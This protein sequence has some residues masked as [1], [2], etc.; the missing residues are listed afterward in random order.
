MTDQI[1]RIRNALAERYEIEREI[2]RGGMAT[3]FRARDLRHKRAVAIKVLHAD[4]AASVGAD[5]FLREIETVAGLSHPHI[6]PLFDSGEAGGFLYYVMPYVDGESLRA[7]LERGGELPVAETVRVLGEVADALQY[8]HHRGVVHRD[9]KPENV[10]FSGRHALVTDFGV[11]KAVSASVSAQSFTTAGMAIG[12]P[13][14]MAPEQAAA[15]PQVDHRADLYALGVLGY[16]ML[17]GEPPFRGRSSQA[18]LAA[19]MTQEPEP[20]DQ[21]RSGAPVALT[22]V[23][24]Q[25]LAK[26]PADRPQSAEQVQRQLENMPVASGTTRTASHPSQKSEKRKAMLAGAAIAVVALVGTALAVRGRGVESTLDPKR[27]VVASFENRTGDSSLDPIG[28]MAVDWLT[29]GLSRT[30][31][32]QVVD[33]RT[34]L[35]EPG[36][37]HA[38][39][40]AGA[41]RL[42]SLAERT[43][44]GTVVWGAYYRE[45]DSIRFQTQITNGGSGELISSIDAVKA[46]AASPADALE[47]LRQK[48]T[49]AL[50]IAYDPKLE[51][52]AMTTTRPP[53]Y[54]AYVA[55]LEGAAAYARGDFSTAAAKHL[56]AANLDPSFDLAALQAAWSHWE[57]GGLAVAD[58]LAIALTG[59]RERLS[60]YDRASLDGLVS[61]IKG[62]YEATLR[63]AREGLR[64]APTSEDAQLALYYAAMTTGRY[65]EALAVLE[66]IDPRRGLYSETSWYASVTANA[67]HMLGDYTREL[68]VVAE[69]RKAGTTTP[70]WLHEPEIRALI[71]LRRLTEANERV[72]AVSFVPPSTTRRY[73][74]MLFLAASEMLAHG[75]VAASRGL[76]ER[77]V[78]WIKGK[79]RDEL[80]KHAA[81]RG[82]ADLL[83]LTSHPQDARPIYERLSAQFPDTIEFQG[84]LGMLAGW[85]GDREGADSISEKIARVKQPY[86]RGAGDFSRACIAAA[87]GDKGRA[88][89]LLAEARTRGAVHFQ[90]VHADDMLRDLRDYP[91]FR[92]TYKQKD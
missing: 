89:A 27:V 17:S 4:L 71:G 16:E 12:T 36:S 21:R 54:E 82:M 38:K 45:G 92:E 81:Q 50:A 6:L 51:G 47:R 88:L 43:G 39:A 24:M 18:I 33:S 9:I 31:I 40:G 90:Y 15:D 59:R 8:A 3:V 28:D 58:S 25:L 60:P 7:R 56:R 55:F 42:R 85:R 63:A 67:L 29:Q 91:A 76:S 87:L 70:V 5:R 84:R 77:G 49:G 23:I 53:T 57:S 62:D 2:G 34:A 11:A 68:E 72:T 32:L 80:A 35:D 78:A 73:G 65:R 83:M 69:A 66:R 74:N 86:L 1:T 48:V 37:P 30:G 10:L 64:V 41:A 22:E 44:A 26:R 79:P 61:W 52:W 46:S 20:L 13:A 14:Y 19:H 75:Y